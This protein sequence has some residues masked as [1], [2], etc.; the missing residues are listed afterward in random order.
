MLFFALHLELLVRI[1]IMIVRRI[2]GHFEDRRKVSR[3]LQPV[4]VTMA[5]LLIQRTCRQVY[6]IT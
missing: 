6:I 2:D 4:P 3:L 1:N 5:R